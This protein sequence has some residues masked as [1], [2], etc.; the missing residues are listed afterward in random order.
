L[1]RAGLDLFWDIQSGDRTLDVT[2]EE[3]LALEKEGKL[4]WIEVPGGVEELTPISAD[5]LEE[6]E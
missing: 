5:V 1:C 4:T 2:K 3:M 6:Y